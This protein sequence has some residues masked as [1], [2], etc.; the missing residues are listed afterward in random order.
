MRRCPKCGAPS[1]DTHQF[2]P[3]CGGDLRQAAPTEEGS[4]VYLGMTIGGKFVLRELIGTGGMG[5]VYRA[6]QVGVGRTVA[7]KIMHRHLLGD[8]T[9]AARFTNEARASSQLNHPNSIS[10][11]DFGQTEVGILYI[12]MEYLRGRSLDRVLEKEFPIPFG[13]VA[14]ILCQ[15]MDAVDAAHKLNI[16]HRDL[17][18]ENVFLEQTGGDDFVKVLDFGVAKML[19]LED[20]TITTPGLVPGTPEYMSPEQARG[21]PLDPR[22]DVYSLGVILYELITGTVPFRGASAL[23]TM[24]SHVQD[25]PQPPSKRAPDRKIPDALDAIVLWALAKRHEER[26][27]TAA[28]FRDILGAWAEVAGLWPA[29]EERRATKTSVLLKYFTQDQLQHVGAGERRPEVLSRPTMPKLQAPRLPDGPRAEAVLAGRDKE[30]RRLDAFLRSERPGRVLHI[31][32]TSGMGR[33][34]LIED[35]LARARE[36]GMRAIHARPGL[37]WAPTVL[38]PALQ[39]ALG[40]LGIAETHATGEEV[41]QA[42]GKLGVEGEEIGGLL[43]LLGLGSHLAEATSESRRRE[44]Q[45][46]LRHVV[47][48]AAARGSLLVVCEEIDR[49]DLPSREMLLSLAAAPS[50]EQVAIIIT[51]APELAQLWPPE[52]EALELAPLSGDASAALVR[53][54]FEQGQTLDPDLVERVC[55]VGRGHPLFLEHLAYGEVHEG[56]REPPEKLADLIA[57]RIEHLPQAERHLLQWMAVVNDWLA[58]GGLS[59]ISGEPVDAAALE[60]LAQRGMLRAAGRRF[61]FAHHLVASVVYSSIPAEVRRKIHAAVAAYLRQLDA[62]SASIAFHSYEADE[63]PAAVEAL[64]R[65]GAWA[66]RCLD[67]AGAS[68]HYSRALNVVR[69][70]W[71]R[72][73]VREGELDQMAVGLARKLAAVLREVGDA[74][75]ARGVLEETLSVAAGD[76]A[77]RAGLR[78]DL[79]RFDLETGNLQRAA[80]HLELALVDAESAKDEWLLGEIKRELAR[81]V[82][83]LQDRERGSKLLHEALE[84]SRRAAG[85]R[86]EAP[87][88]TLLEVANICV[89]IGFGGRA[90]GYL[91]DALQQAE[92]ER[93][94]LGKLQAVARMAELHQSASEW[95]EAEIRLGQALDLVGQLGDRTRRARLLTELG[96]VHRIQGNVEQGR[97]TLDSAVRVARAIAWW[98]GLKR[99]EAEIEMLRYAKPQAL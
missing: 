6:D 43:E 19:D 56:L 91:L 61:A 29:E 41:L 83:L 44:R 27:A 80:R 71:G 33:S 82:G 18:P 45:S 51:H 50:K 17:K 28:Q 39:V 53:G 67:L 55:R 32:G 90:R 42:A 75:A 62:S 38:G 86:A 5:K 12:V 60:R 31:Q 65:A 81:A 97:R 69:G 88:N 94:L 93:S 77:S 85:K 49:Y 52:V 79:G 22:S 16:I 95:G 30:R 92:S 9:A 54:L 13:R 98:E 10:V 58:P 68:Q 48:R 73:R 63:G 26:I 15:A 34:R 2:C 3:G 66:A 78:L 74:V 46:A 84:H 23:A 11:L 24:M 21:E 14:S 87:W 40:C 59:A 25:P 64:D 72:G 76:D 20:R 70:E 96:K 57:M 36:L 37:G 1:L 7:V 47:Q 8:E 89:Q 35:A 4:D 99:A